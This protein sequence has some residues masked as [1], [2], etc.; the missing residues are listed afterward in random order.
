MLRRVS[1]ILDIS[2]VELKAAILR[3]QEQTLDNFLN[4]TVATPS[5]QTDQFKDGDND[6]Y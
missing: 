3:D 6:L 1:E 5:D 2:S 4:V